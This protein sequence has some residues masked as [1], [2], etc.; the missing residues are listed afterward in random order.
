MQIRETESVLV[1]LLGEVELDELMEPK[2]IV[3]LVV[4]GVVQKELDKVDVLELQR[5][6]RELEEALQNALPQ[7][8]VFVHERLVEIERQTEQIGF[9]ALTNAGQF[10]HAEVVADHID[11][12]LLHAVVQFDQVELIEYESTLLFRLDDLRVQLAQQ[13]AATML[14]VAALQFAYDRRILTT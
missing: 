1:L 5:T 12:R 14:R 3:V 6:E 7:Q 8:L 2:Q 11:A 13:I 4:L 10:D 9:E